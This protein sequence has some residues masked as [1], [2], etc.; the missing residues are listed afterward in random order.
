VTDRA[1]LTGGNAPTGTITFR[2][3]GPSATSVCN[4]GNLVFTSSAVAVNGSGTYGSAPGFT[5][6]AAGTYR[7]IASYSGD[8]NNAAVAGACGDT[9]ESVVIAQATPTLATQASAAISLG[10]SV[11]DTATLSGGTNPTGTITFRLYGPDDATCASAAVFTS[12]A[13][14]VNGNGSY[15]S[16]PSYT[17]S[18]VGTYRWIASYGGD[19][20]HVAVAGSCNDAN[21]SVVVS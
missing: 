17:P 21:E 4:A 7:W 18:A 10:G 2:L 6:T 14:T 11:T 15:V 8:A 5:P 20:N 9:N 13:V 3:Y 1:S 16:A 12:I 19:A